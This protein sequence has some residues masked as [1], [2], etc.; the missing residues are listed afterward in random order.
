MIKNFDHAEKV[1][2]RRFKLGKKGIA[3]AVCRW[4]AKQGDLVTRRDLWLQ[5]AGLIK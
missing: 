5:L 4:I 2:A 1:Q 3:K